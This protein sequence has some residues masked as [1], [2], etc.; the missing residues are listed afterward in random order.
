MSDNSKRIEKLKAAKDAGHIDTDTFEAAVA[1][2]SIKMDARVEGSGAVAQSG[3]GNAVAAS[4][5]GIAIGEVHGDVYVGRKPRNQKAA[6]EAYRKVYVATCRHLPLRGIDIGASDATAGG[7]RMDLAKVYV[8][9]DTTSTRE[10]ESRNPKR[11][12][13]PSKAEM[14]DG[15]LSIPDPDEKETVPLSAIEAITSHRCS[16]ILGDPGS[17]KST[18][19]NHLGLCLAAYGLEPEGGWLQRLSNWP[20]SDK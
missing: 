6:L 1:G 2:L 4:D 16:V 18:F 13:Q 7:E 11:R 20:D 5:R 12:W 3:S 17:G 8:D 14:P 10:I 15:L 19:L 9:L